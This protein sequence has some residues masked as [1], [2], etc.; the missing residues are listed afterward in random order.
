[1]AFPK[2]S[3]VI[4]LVLENVSG[5]YFD[6]LASTE[7]I[8]GQKDFLGCTRPGYHGLSLAARLALSAKLVNSLAAQEPHP[9][10]SYRL[11]NL[12]KSSAATDRLLADCM[13]EPLG[14]CSA[15]V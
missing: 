9:S 6:G 14:F 3:L 10:P 7:A 2:V 15:N 13:S 12:R 11:S 1:L 4:D 5:K 8:F